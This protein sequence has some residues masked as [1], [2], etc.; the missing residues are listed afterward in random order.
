MNSSLVCQNVS[1]YRRCADGSQRAIL[2][3]VNA[4]LNAGQ[5]IMISGETGAGKSIIISAIELLL[6]A[7]ADSDSIRSGCE[8]AH[9]RAIFAN[10]EKTAETQRARLARRRSVVGENARRHAGAQV[11][12]VRLLPPTTD[13]RDRPLPAGDGGRFRASLTAARGRH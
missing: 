8:N 3:D 7:R 9:I 2:K 12:L 6:G 1:L 10:G 4:T 11:P 13:R 5:G